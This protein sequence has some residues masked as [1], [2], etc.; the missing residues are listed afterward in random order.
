MRVTVSGDRRAGQSG[1]GS[2]NRSQVV[3]ITHSCSH[4]KTAMVEEGQSGSTAF[5]SVAGQSRERERGG[6]SVVM[7]LL[8]P[9][10]AS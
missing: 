1:S 8:L 7:I 4:R 2:P 9:T 3:A 5:L 10:T 6:T